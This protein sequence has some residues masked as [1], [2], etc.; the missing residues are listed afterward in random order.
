MEEQLP[1]K[2]PHS[3]STHGA[4]FI[5][6]LLRL[7]HV[8]LPTI[9]REGSA[10]GLAGQSV[11]LSQFRAS[12]TLKGALVLTLA[13]F[14]VSNGWDG[15]FQHLLCSSHFSSS[16]TLSSFLSIHATGSHTECESRSGWKGKNR[17]NVCGETS[18]KV[19][20]V[21]AGLKPEPV[22]QARSALLDRAKPQMRNALESEHVKQVC[23]H[24]EHVVDGGCQDRSAQDGVTAVA[25]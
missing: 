17:R 6:C 8:E 4:K 9:Q 12:S 24:T 1:W 10:K 20:S 16:S 2:S 3:Q 5:F 14:E 15:T 11:T 7:C 21:Q 18:R 13:P 25:G 23:M 22:V 19:A